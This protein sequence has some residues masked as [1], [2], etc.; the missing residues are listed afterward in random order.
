MANSN[1]LPS[2]WRW[3]FGDYTQLGPTFQKFLSNLN[4]F[5]L[6]V[7]NLLNGGIGFSNLQ[8]NVYVTTVTGGASITSLTFSNPLTIPPSGLTVV[9]IGLTSGAALSLMG[10]IGV[11][12][13]FYDGKNINI[14]N[15]TGLSAGIS[16]KI[17]IEVM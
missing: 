11:A 12:N 14:V 3:D 15:I 17:S 1:P 13:W 16:Y 5:A 7:Y 9:Q 8:R 4:I 6:A 2:T 10:A